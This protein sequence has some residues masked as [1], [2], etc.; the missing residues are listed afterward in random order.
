MSENN[1]ICFICKKDI[2]DLRLHQ[3]HV[4][5]CHNVSLHELFCRQF[6]CMRTFTNCN[7]LYSHIKRKHCIKKLTKDNAKEASC[8][9]KSDDNMSLEEASS[10]DVLSEPHDCELTFILDLFSN[11][12]LTRADIKKIVN[13][14]KNLLKLKVN[15]CQDNSFSFM[16]TESKLIE[17]LKENIYI[18]SHRLLLLAQNKKRLKEKVKFSEKQ[19]I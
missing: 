17:K 6:G 19:L 13:S 12:N 9:A 16:D 4:R 11:V 2:G 15:D 3:K 5:H 10:H 14:S 18:C 7:S 1:Y 8:S